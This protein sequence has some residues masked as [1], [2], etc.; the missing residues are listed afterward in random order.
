MDVVDTE[1]SAAWFANAQAIVNIG[2]ARIVLLND[3][4]MGNEYYVQNIGQHGNGAFLDGVAVFKFK[5]YHATSERT[6]LR[7]DKWTRFNPAV[8]YEGTWWLDTNKTVVYDMFFDSSPQM[9]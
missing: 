1:D 6:Y 3:V 8:Q 4:V 2:A 7:V 9:F 5:T